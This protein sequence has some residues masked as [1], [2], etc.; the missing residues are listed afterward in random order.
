MKLPARLGFMKTKHRSRFLVTGQDWAP[1][2]D[3]AAA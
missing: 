2:V 3:L 1:W